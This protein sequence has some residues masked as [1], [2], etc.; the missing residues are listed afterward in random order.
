MHVRWWLVVVVLCG[1]AAVVHAEGDGRVLVVNAVRVQPK[2][3]V[4]AQSKLNADLSVGASSVIDAETAGCAVTECLPA[5]GAA[6]GFDRVALLSGGPN[7]DEGYD[8]RAD[9]WTRGAEL[10]TTNGTC[11]FCMS[12]DMAHFAAKLVQSLL[13]APPVPRP[14]VPPAAHSSPTTTVTP[15]ATS[16]LPSPAETPVQSSAGRPASPGLVVPVAFSAV[17]VAALAT[18]ISLWVLDG[19]GASGS[20]SSGAPP[21]CSLAYDTKTAGEILTGIGAAGIA[22]GAVLLWRAQR[23]PSSTQVA[24][25]PASVFIWRSF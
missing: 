13:M 16:P 21:G 25:G 22:V 6:H 8:L 5:V 17:G 23:A 10:Q 18:G 20:C 9:L 14:S 19:H 15:T 7:G 3:A 12:G 11:N 1:P 2:T 4:E 24:I